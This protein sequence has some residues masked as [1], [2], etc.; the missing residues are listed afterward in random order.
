[1]V[2]DVTCVFV[3]RDVSMCPGSR[4]VD[5]SSLQRCVI[6]RDMWQEDVTSG[7]VLTIYMD[8]TRPLLEHD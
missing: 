4:G 3:T 6:E 1:M 5:V 2:K 8:A 7:K